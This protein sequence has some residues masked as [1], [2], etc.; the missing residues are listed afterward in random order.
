MKVRTSVKAG[1]L[2]SNHSEAR[3]TAVGVKTQTS[4]KAGALSS[5]HSEARVRRA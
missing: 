4:V 3:A 1:A 2:S 5:N